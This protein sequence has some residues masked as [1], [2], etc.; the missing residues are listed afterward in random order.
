MKFKFLLQS[1]FS[2]AIVLLA[3]TDTF[4][5]PTF[6]NEIPIPPLLDAS[7]GPIELEMRKVSHKF[8]PGN[9]QDTLLNGTANQDGIETW[10]YNLAGDDSMSFLGPT[11]KWHTGQETNIR[12]HNLLPQPTTTHWHGAEVP[13]HLDGGPHQPIWPDETWPVDFIN[14]D[15]AST[16]WYHP[17]FHNNTYPQVQL[18]LSGMIISEQATDP[19]RPVLPHTYGVDDIPVIISDQSFLF[20]SALQIMRVDTN[21][22]KR[23]INL[24]NGYTNPY[25]EVPAH[26][27]RL[28]ILNGSTRKGIQF[29]ISSSYDSD[30]LSALEDFRLIATDGGY[31]LNPVTMKTILTG[32]GARTEIVLDLTAYNPGDTIYLRNL[33]HLMPGSIVGSPHPTTGPGGGGDVTGGEAFLQLRIVADPPNYTPINNFTPFITSWDPTLQDTFDV[34]RHRTK[35][36]I[37]IPKDL[38]ADPPRPHNAFTIDSLTYNL[39]TINDTI[40]EGAKEIWTIHNKT[41]VAHPFHIHK[42]FFRILDIDSL[43]TSIDLESRGFN[44]PK[45]DVLVRPN[46][47]LRFLASFNGY[48]NPI[49]FDQ[50]YMYHCHILTH[51]DAEGGGMMHQFVVTDD[52]ACVPVQV[53]DRVEEKLMTLYPNPATQELFL[54]SSSTKS[55]QLHI[56]DIQGRV[57]KSQQLPAFDE[58]IPIDIAGLPTGFYIVSW[59]HT[60]GVVSRKV[61]IQ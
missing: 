26:L 29:G 45:D 58:K 51:E 11:L 28:R 31:T 15:S 46:W 14:L 9:I 25:V 17:H 49:A 3:T 60:S 43:G 48:P 40:C 37:L 39:M 56:L 32:P 19:I 27:V 1:I 22:A 23:P 20:D 24:V 35:D 21:K 34:S 36:L 55:S 38:D 16:M 59:Q 7:D 50:S 44:G 5:Q 61:I 54:E 42:I 18:G 8:N 53:D 47:K 41:E 6:Y 57:I 30:D 13:A 33:K 4:A 12:V 10:C 52:P 2:V